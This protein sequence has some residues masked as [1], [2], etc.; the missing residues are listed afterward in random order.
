[1]TDPLIVFALEMESCGLFDKHRLIH[2][3][4]G[5]TQA[6]YALTKAISVKRPSRV[7]NLGSAGSAVHPAGTLVCCTGFV[8]RDM[9]VSPLGIEKYATPFLDC[10]VV[11]KNGQKVPDLPPA[12]CGTGDSFEIAHSGEIYDVVDMEAWSLAYICHKEGIPFT[13]LKF[14]S[15]GADGK[16]ADD[17]KKALDD[18]AHK[19][20]DGLQMIISESADI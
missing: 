7:I 2:S 1:M 17:W 14:I 4:V 16:A 9:D 20:H 19:L 6:S 11:L 8:Q 5:K 13:C 3:G 12:I 15:D 10:A 18:G